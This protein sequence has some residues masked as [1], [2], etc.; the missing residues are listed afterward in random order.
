MRRIIIFFRYFVVF[1]IK[2]MYNYVGK[3]IPMN[4]RRDLYENF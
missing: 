1:Q 2:I 3:F 4:T